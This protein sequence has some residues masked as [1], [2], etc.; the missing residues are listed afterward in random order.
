[1]EQKKELRKGMLG[2]ILSFVMVFGLM[3]GMSLTAL[4]DSPLPGVSYLD[5]DDAEKKLVEKTGDSACM[6]YTVVGADTTAWGESNAEKWYVANSDITISTRVTVAGIANLILCDDVELTIEKGI[7]VN[8]GNTLNIYAQSGRTGKLYAGTTNGTD[9]TCDDNYAGIGGDNQKPGGNINVYGGIV[10]ATGGQNGAGIGSVKDNSGGNINVYSGTIT[11]TGGEAAPGI[12]IWND[13]TD[14]VLKVYGGN[15]EATGG[16]GN[17]SNNTPGGA[18]ISYA[19]DHV[20]GD[21][22][23]TAVGG[24]GAKNNEGVYVSEG[25][26]GISGRINVVSDSPKITATGGAGTNGGDGIRLVLVNGDPLVALTVTSGSPT[27]KATGGN[28]TTG[29]GGEGISTGSIAPVSQPSALVITSG[30]PQ[31]TSTGGNSISGEAGDGIYGSIKLGENSGSPSVLAIRGDGLTENVFSISGAAS[32]PAGF[33]I[34]VKTDE[35]ELWKPISDGSGPWENPDLGVESKYARIARFCIVALE[36]N[37]GSGYMDP[38]YYGVN[39]TVTLPL[40]SFTRAGYSFAGWNTMEDGSGTSYADGASVTLPYDEQFILY[41]QWEKCPDP[42]IMKLPAAIPG[43][44]CNDKAQTLITPGEADGGSF[45]YALGM[46]A[47]TSPADDLYTASI[48]TGIEAGTYY[49]W[50]MVEGDANHSDTKPAVI[51]VEIKSK[52][53]PTPGPAE[54]IRMLR[55]YNPNSGEHFYTRYEKEKENLVAEGWT[56]EGGGFYALKTSDKPV[57]RL[58]NPIAGDHHYTGSI[59]E[60]DY[61]VSAGWNYEGI[62]LYASDAQNGVKVYRMYNPNSETA[63]HH[64]TTSEKEKENLEKLGWKFEGV[65]FYACR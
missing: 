11:A 43:L 26:D 64:F 25:G 59:K 4:A 30:S 65:A 7:T 20:S 34:F 32:I 28:A 10:T 5:W 60:R 27:I 1:M 41:A 33:M 18:G 58:Y 48:P 56:F 40:N 9:R 45:L 35:N 16:A 36:A 22:A 38:L 44:V 24:E 13:F 8:E 29:T 37:G 31:I 21:A 62:A 57:Y 46:D 2:I 39:E 15:I 3:P 51:T 6:E 63:S 14:A 55:L 17:S 61:L 12:G 54:K 50:Y 19:V 49:V 53:D 47:N 23:I 42:V 52:D